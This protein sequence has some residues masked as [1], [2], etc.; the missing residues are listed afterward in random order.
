MGRRKGAD[1][2]EQA[3]QLIQYSSGSM[4]QVLSLFPL[5]SI[6]ALVRT[7]TQFSPWPLHGFAGSMGYADKMRPPSWVALL[8]SSAS[9]GQT[10]PQSPRACLARHSI[11]RSGD[12]DASAPGVATIWPRLKALKAVFNSS[13]LSVSAIFGSVGFHRRG[14]VQACLPPAV[15]TSQSVFQGFKEFFF[16]YLINVPAEIDKNGVI[17]YR[18]L[19]NEHRPQVHFFSASACSD[20]FR[21]W[22]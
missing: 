13:L 3:L 19:S 17:H 16:R 10:F 4:R 21:R 14:T 8:F 2:N 20:S 1:Q 22:S 12:T 5:S 11:N 9:S 6:V 18:C 7:Q 15:R